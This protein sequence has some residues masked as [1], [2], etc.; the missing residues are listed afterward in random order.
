MQDLAIGKLFQSADEP[1]VTLLLKSHG[2][3]NGFCPILQV[4]VSS[5]A[6]LM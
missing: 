3:A 5:F 1:C 2:T 6:T 4:S